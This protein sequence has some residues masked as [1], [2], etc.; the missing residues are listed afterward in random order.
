MT[1]VT[2]V[3]STEINNTK[4][5]EEW[6]H[7][8]NASTFEMSYFIR[9]HIKKFLPVNWIFW[10]WKNSDPKNAWINEFESV[11]KLSADDRLSIS[12]ALDIQVPASNLVI[13]VQDKV[14]SIIEDIKQFLVNGMEIMTQPDVD[15]YVQSTELVVS[16]NPIV[17]TFENSVRRSI[18]LE[19]WKQFTQ[20]LDKNEAGKSA[21]ELNQLKA[22]ARNR[23]V[24]LKQREQAL[25]NM[26]V[27]TQKPEIDYVATNKLLKDFSKEQDIKSMD[28]LRMHFVQRNAVNLTLELSKQIPG[29]LYQLQKGSSLYTLIR[30]NQ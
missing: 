27:Y 29:S 12:K 26:K 5:E 1:D 9:Q 15:N 21:E 4:N 3:K 22:M 17:T 14:N 20:L 13:N 6:I 10:N 19:K 24:V 28:E 16:N 23:L 7:K 25:E 30:E 2:E 11:N 8:L 18:F